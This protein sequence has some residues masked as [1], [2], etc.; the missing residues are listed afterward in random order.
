[1]ILSV[2]LANFLWVGSGYVLLRKWLGMLVMFFYFIASYLL[3]FYAI[4]YPVIL[5][6]SFIANLAFA[7]HAGFLAFIQKQERGY[8]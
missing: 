2:A 6:I 8:P 1:M 5:I 4:S 7:L 3:F